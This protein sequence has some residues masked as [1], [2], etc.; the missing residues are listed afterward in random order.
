MKNR[1]VLMLFFIILA[2]ALNAAPPR[3]QYSYYTQDSGLSRTM[4][5]DISQ[6]GNGCLWMATWSGLY[7]FDGK[8]FTNYKPG[9]TDSQGRQANMRFDRIH[10]DAFGL[11]WALS[12][13]KTLYRFELHKET[14]TKVECG[15]G[16]SEIYRLASDDFLLL[17]VNN[18]LLKVRFSDRGKSIDLEE[19]MRLPAGE[20]VNDVH[21]D[22]ED[23]V[24]VLTDK[25][26][27]RNRS[28][29][30]TRPAYCYEEMDGAV[31][32][33]SD[34]GI[35]VEYI[36]GRFFELDTYTARDIKMICNIRG[37]LKFIIGS[38][39]DG[40]NILNFEGWKLKRIKGDFYSVGE[41]R[42]I[43]D[44]HGNIW[45]CSTEGGICLFD[46][47]SCSLEP[48][49]L[50]GSG[51][52]G[53]DA[54]TNIRCAFVDRQDNV[55]IG[56]SWSGV[57]KAVLKEYKF[58]LA[59]PQGTA[60]DS[61]AK[62][63][64]ALMQ[65]SSGII[66]AGTKDGKVHLLDKNLKPL[67][68]WNAGGIAY[69]I[70]EDSEGRIWLGTKGKGVIEN[71]VI[72]DVGIPAFRP[73]RHGESGTPAAAGSQLVYCVRQHGSRLW[74]AS[75]DGKLTYSELDGGRRTFTGIVEMPDF[76]SEPLRKVRHIAFSP[77]GKML[78]G[79]INGL[80]SCDNPDDSPE[81]L[82][83]E[84]YEDVDKYDIQHILI[85][86]D[87]TMYASSYGKG[88]LQFDGRRVLRTWTGRD[89]LLSDF[90]LSAA[91]DSSGD[92]WIVTYKGLNKLNPATGAV[93]GWSYDR[94]GHDLLFNEGE[95]VITDDGRIL[96]NTTEGILS[97]NPE[98]ISHSSY[99]P[100]VFTRAFYVSGKRAF[101]DSDHAIRMRS[102]ETLSVDFTAVDMCSPESIACFW[103]LDGGGRNGDWNRLDRSGLI[104]LDRLRLGKHSLEM[105]S[106]NADG[107]DINNRIEMGIVVRP[108][109]QWTIIAVLLMFI[110]LAAVSNRLIHRM[111][112]QKA[113]IPAAEPEEETGDGLNGEERRFKETFLACLESNLDNGDV[114]SDDIASA[115]NIS[116]SVLFEKCR[117]VLGK[118]PTEYLRDLRFEKAAEMV[119]EGSLPIAEIAYRT[120]FNDAHYFS[121]AFRKR[122][123]MT[124][125]EYRKSFKA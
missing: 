68:V 80:Y 27:Y 1:A 107:Q 89:G 86:S 32:I 70:S 120:G 3:Y 113:G 15:S 53:W 124:P 96:L 36:N 35:I 61:D 102:G 60:V 66:Y 117:A 125:S 77:S 116:R 2:V 56:G 10:T 112:L 19:Y 17:T 103:R 45:I 44:S 88:F 42:S 51:V 20:T 25:A 87:G 54:E 62:S 115:L 79:G 97:F 34:G 18:V 75:F 63:V 13:D 78:V 81:L 9:Q 108:E 90:V 52:A 84:R 100:K 21:K 55:W 123:G 76:P 39:A 46:P 122:Y 29:A 67:T 49:Y 105:K 41:P 48:F 121:K 30:S 24:W 99:I 111:R 74:I 94:I 11:L 101:H 28:V 12:Y 83:F 7:R 114:T 92:I 69:S 82:R 14:F 5:E 57:G 22:A 104:T 93:T 47:E 72:N 43:R 58:T 64:R 8:R 110:G 40:Y 65:S 50:D 71:A 109:P 98:E 59:T 38:A 23:N 106:T 37:T 85:S 118:A 31:Y 119:K 73:R 6:D 26:L 4:V 95:P 91:E 33:G 16:I